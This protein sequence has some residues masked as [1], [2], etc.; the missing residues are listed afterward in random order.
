MYPTFARVGN[1]GHHLITGSHGYACIHGVA[2]AAGPRRE[3]GCIALCNCDGRTSLSGCW[4]ASSRVWT[5]STVRANRAISPFRLAA[6]RE[7]T[8]SA[9]ASGARL[10]FM[11]NTW[12]V[13]LLVVRSA[14]FT[15]PIIGSLWSYKLISSTFC[16]FNF[17]DIHARA[18]TQSFIN[19]SIR[20]RV[21]SVTDSSK[22]RL[23][24]KVESMSLMSLKLNCHWLSD[25]FNNCRIFLCNW[26]IER[27]R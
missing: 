23:L 12:L 24:I 4:R 15:I 11:G 2:C 9:G 20:K 6:Q 1:R 22:L 17:C 3:R 18:H 16:K 19:Y 10:C 8:W 7:L 27:S 5:I 25:Y 21:R 13:E 14:V 26:I